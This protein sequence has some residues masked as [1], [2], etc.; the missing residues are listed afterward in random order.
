M[1]SR[2]MHDILAHILET[3]AVEHI[4]VPEP[5]SV[6]GNRD[7]FYQQYMQR[8]QE[9]LTLRNTVR[10]RD[11]SDLPVDVYE[12]FLGLLEN[13]M[14]SGQPIDVNRRFRQVYLSQ[15]DSMVNPESFGMD[16][17]LEF[18]IGEFD[19]EQHRRDLDRRY[20]F[21]RRSARVNL[22][23]EGVNPIRVSDDFQIYGQKTVKI[24]KKQEDHFEDDLFKV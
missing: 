7:N 12:E 6:F 8:P 1:P 19:A 14:R 3:S 17:R 15:V 21:P 18:K 22:Y 20:S 10:E 23:D 16:F 11:L 2:I 13:W 24:K 5:V 9:L 4:D